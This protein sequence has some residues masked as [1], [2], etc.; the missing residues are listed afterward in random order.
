MNDNNNNDN[1]F[2]E[3][4]KETV[5]KVL[6]TPR[7]KTTIYSFVLYFIITSLVTGA[8][9]PFPS[10]IDVSQAHVALINFVSLLITLVGSLIGVGFYVERRNNIKLESQNYKID[11]IDRKI[12]QKVDW[13]Y[14]QMREMEQRICTN[15]DNKI[16]NIEKNIDLKVQQAKILEDERFKRIE[17]KHHEHERRIDT[18]D[19][20]SYE[21]TTRGDKRKTTT[22]RSRR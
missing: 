14:S 8:P 10:L 11:R 4:V 13:L 9:F 6:N 18:L 19:R 21:Y 7:K 17:D 16:S 15:M 2:I 5:E 20:D 12:D 1:K 3:P 22:T